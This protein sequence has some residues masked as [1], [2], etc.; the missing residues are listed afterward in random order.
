MPKF[1]A[2]FA[3]VKQKRPFTIRQYGRMELAQLYC[4]DIQ[5][6]SAWVKMKVWIREHPGLTGRLQELGYDG[7]TRSFT[8]AQ[9]QAIADALGA[10]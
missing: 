4:P 10:P 2:I 1:I 3:A 9:V 7:R 8:P 6:E 5:P